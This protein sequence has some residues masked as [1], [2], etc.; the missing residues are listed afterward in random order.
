MKNGHTF[1]TSPAGIIEL[2]EAIAN[3]LKKDNQIAYDPSQIV[4]GAGSKQIL[5]NLFQVLCNTGDEVIIPI[6]AWNTFVEQVKLA[7]AKP[8]LIKLLP[9]FKLK[10]NEVKKVLTKN[11]KILLI[12]SPSNP[13]GAM[14]DPE[15]LKKIADLAVKNNIIIITDEIY[16]KLTYTQKQISIASLSE[17][18]KDIT[19]TTGGL[20][21]SYAMTGWRVGYA[22]GP[23]NIIDNM[24]KLQSQMLTQTSSISQYGAVEA[25]SGNQDSV[26][27]MKKQFE[28]RR[29]Y[30]MKELDT[31]KDITYTKPE[32]AF[33]LFINV[34][35]LL[36][37]NYSTSALW[38]Q[39][40]L[41]TEKVAVVPGE[42]FFYP[43]YIRMSYAASDEDLKEALVRIKKFI[44]NNN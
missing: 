31:I 7:G 42:A 11:T 2:R 10:V 18:I 30:C 15:E 4:V 33:Y 9:P 14:I 34:E 32:G 22:A 43:G 23:K 29:E 44:A 37:K 24:I 38:A 26:I 21:K 39:G 19:V 20:S 40:L 28:K 6:P 12:N 25:L 16:E 5:F 17:Q 8:V 3:K 36:H 35:K 41:E 1:Y 27:K 13:T